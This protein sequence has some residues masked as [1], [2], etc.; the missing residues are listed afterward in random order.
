MKLLVTGASGFIGRNLIG[1]LPADWHVTAT[2]C[3]SDSFPNFVERLGKSHIHPLRIDLAQSGAAERIKCFGDSFDACI[4]LAANGDPAKS[5]VD[6][7]FDLVSNTLSLIHVVEKVRFQRF[8][9][10][11]S[12][13]VYDGL[14]GPVSPQVAVAPLLPYAI[15][16]LAS[17]RYLQHFQRALSIDNLFIVRFFGAYG[18]LEP[19]RKI[20]NRLV[21]QFAFEHDPRFTIRG[22]GKNLI[23]AMYIDDAVRA[24]LALLNTSDRGAIL[25]CASGAPVSLKAL[26]ETA[27]E[28]FGMQAEITYTGTVPEYIDFYSVDSAMKSK[29]DFIPGIDLRE[30]LRK[31]AGFL[32]DPAAYLSNLSG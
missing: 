29:Y 15:S 10:F 6:P 16:K 12:G 27:A 21:R 17:E 28:V 19:N 8:I 9:Y 30:G 2:Y 1:A 18:P 25:D 13:A 24:I 23:D 22:D 11:S 31:F 5:V 20:Y 4:F 26:V 32:Q 7:A 14:A 3:K